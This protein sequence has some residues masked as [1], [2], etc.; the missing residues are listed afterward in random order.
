MTAHPRSRGEN[1]RR[2]DPGTTFIGSSPLTRG[3]HYTSSVGQVR[4][5]L[6]PAHAGKTLHFFCWSGSGSAHPRSRGEN[7]GNTLWGAGKSGSS[8]LTRGKQAVDRRGGPAGGLIPAHAGKTAHRM[9]AGSRLAAHPR[10]RG[11]NRGG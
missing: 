11:E 2:A 5:R 6:I 9:L 4:V 1:T 3:K 10:S 8:P 7:L